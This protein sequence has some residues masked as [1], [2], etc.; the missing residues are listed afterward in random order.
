MDERV[1]VTG[2]TGFIG[3]ELIKRLVS[4]GKAVNALYRS[5]NK[6][7]ELPDFPGKEKVQFFKGTLDDKEAIKNAMDGC[8][9][10]YHIAAL[11]RAWSEQEDDFHN[12]NVVGTR[13]ILN[14]A[15]ETG[16]S[17][18]VF[19]STGGTLASGEKN[20]PADE[21]TERL[22]GFYNLYEKTK[23][24][25]EKEVKKFA[26]EGVETVI[27]NPTR[28]YGPG[29]ISIS[30]AA[31]RLIELY[32]KGKWRLMLGNGDSVG[33]FTFVT[34][35]VEGHL[36][37]MEYGKSGEQYIIG[38]ENLTLMDYFTKIAEQS[39]N[40]Y[41]MVKVPMAAALIFAKLQKAKADIFKKPPMI[42]PEWVK[43][44]YQNWACSSQ[45]AREELG[46]QITPADQAIQETIKWINQ[47][48]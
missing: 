39:G 36:K 3:L 30:N 40:H 20:N 5:D 25:A 24:I 4:Q 34:D 29:H 46:Y 44:Y 17:R 6:V 9:Q 23:F 43:K 10:V 38:G 13:N 21:N 12:I 35:V 48:D 2:G 15:Y 47:Q 41:K 42:T 14:A 8:K 18:V 22:T 31:T 1:F 45:K 26:E 37:A 19:T 33:N 11:A 7:K 28:V 16:A 32:M 27:V